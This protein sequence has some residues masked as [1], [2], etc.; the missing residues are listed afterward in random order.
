MVEARP[1]AETTIEKIS[2]C[3]KIIEECGHNCYGIKGEAKC[4]PCLSDDH[5]ADSVIEQLLKDF[6][7]IESDLC[8]ICL[9]ELGEFACVR[10]CEKHALHGTCMKEYLLAGYSTLNITFGWMSC[11]NCRKELIIPKKMP[12]LGPIL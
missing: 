2:F 7:S 10:I 3:N 1:A 6:N 11:P 5:K 12:V 4:L 9:E 8:G